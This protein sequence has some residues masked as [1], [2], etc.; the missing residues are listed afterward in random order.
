MLD[1]GRVEDPGDSSTLR[2]SLFGE[3]EIL[4]VMFATSPAGS[5]VKGRKKNVLRAP[6]FL[7]GGAWSTSST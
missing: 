2:W 1:R 5:P 6:P 7:H 3:A 4:T